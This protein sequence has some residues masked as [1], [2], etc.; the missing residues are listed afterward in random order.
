[1]QLH[2]G[3]K[4]INRLPLGDGGAFRLPTSGARP[5]DPAPRHVVRTLSGK[6]ELSRLAPLP[7]ERSKGKNQETLLR[8]DNLSRERIAPH[9]PTSSTRKRG[10]NHTPG[11]LGEKRTV[12]PDTEKEGAPPPSSNIEE[13]NRSL[14]KK[15]VH[16][17]LLGKGVERH[18]DAYLA[19]FGTTCQGAL[20]TFRHTV[21][22]DIIDRQKAAS[23]I[24]RHL[25]MYL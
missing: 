18:D 2:I 19:C 12:L 23:V 22:T 9:S 6:Q 14:I 16:Y 8:K 1:M 4:V 20:V 21:K 17:Q 24:E 10:G 13:R 25:D 5:D 3:K 15:L 7:M 11:R